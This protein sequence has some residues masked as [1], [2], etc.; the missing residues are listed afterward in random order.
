M[1]VQDK[2]KDGDTMDLTEDTIEKS[3]DTATG[4]EKD[5]AQDRPK[6]RVARRGF[7][8]TN[9]GGTDSAGPSAVKADSSAME[10]T[11]DGAQDAGAKP[12]SSLQKGEDEGESKPPVKGEQVFF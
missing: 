10:V 11:P 2:D 12:A 3:A 5:S 4:A 7:S 6:K 8:D 1:C 9:V